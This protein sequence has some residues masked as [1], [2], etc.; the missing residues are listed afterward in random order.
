[1]RNASVA[2]LELFTVVICMGQHI[3]TD[4]VRT[5]TA[6]DSG[7]GNDR[8][9]DISLR[10]ASYERTTM[11]GRLPAAESR[12]RTMPMI[13]TGSLFAAAVI[14][15]HVYQLNAWWKDD[16]GPFH[17]QEDWPYDLQIDKF[18]HFYGSY[19]ISYATR[20]VLLVDGFT[21]AAA[22]DWGAVMGL[23]YELY[24]ETEDGFSTRWGFSPTDAAMDIAGAAYFFLQRRIPV[25]QNFHEKWSYY[26]SEFLGSGSIP[27]QKRTFVDDYQGQSFWWTA[28][29]WNLLPEESR[30]WY[31]KW[32]QPAIGY[33]V[34]NYDPVPSD[35]PTI[36]EVY[37]GLDLSPVHLL[38][39]STAPFIRWLV[40]AAENIHLPAPALQIVPE[41]KFHLLY[42]FRF[43]WGS[44]TF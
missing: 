38:P 1:M 43:T 3:P 6:A 27:G 30:G 20:E 4:G 39:S 32:L 35:V 17:I 29:V 2:L 26:P 21:D 31:P 14:G 37:L 18:G 24:V 5:V 36:R 19:M 7:S 42:P 11:D 10:W 22:H 15:L 44:R 40:Q 16:R 25:L 28:D 13:V 34:K 9:N 41:T 12:V 23:T 8:Q 33:S